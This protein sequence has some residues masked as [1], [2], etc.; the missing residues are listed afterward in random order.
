MGKPC[1]KHA[2]HMFLACLL[3]ISLCVQGDTI[4][5]VGLMKFLNRWRSRGEKNGWQRSRGAN[6][7]GSYARKAYKRGICHII[8]SLSCTANAGGC[9]CTLLSVCLVPSYLCA[10][11]FFRELGVGPTE[12][13]WELTGVFSICLLLVTFWLGVGG[14]ENSPSFAEAISPRVPCTIELHKQ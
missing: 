11:P 5:S 2:T 14:I 10:K 6:T 12:E 8:R 7:Q 4:A 9:T 1:F 3:N 13:D